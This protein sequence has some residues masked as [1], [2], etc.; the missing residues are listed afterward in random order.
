[1]KRMPSIVLLVLFCLC[2]CAKEATQQIKNSSIDVS[3]M[4]VYDVSELRAYF[5]PHHMT[6]ALHMGE[7]DDMTQEQFTEKMLTYQEIDQQFPV[8]ILKTASPV[9]KYI[10]Y[11][12]RQGGFYYVFLAYFEPEEL[13]EQTPKTIEYMY[14]RFTAYLGDSDTSADYSSVDPYKVEPEVTTM[15]DIIELDPYVE[16]VFLSA[17]TYTCSL[18]DNST[19]LQI[20]YRYKQGNDEPNSVT[21]ESFIAVD[22]AIKEIDD[23]VSIFAEIV[24]TRGQG[25]G[26]VVS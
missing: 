7:L 1:M 16:P 4:K 21:Y 23:S 19:I 5:S 20:K 22:V 24:G 26:S 2:G 14:V 12:V 6:F 10:M 9:C 11:P 25:D 13:G 8:E 18:L 17:G 3:G 15:M